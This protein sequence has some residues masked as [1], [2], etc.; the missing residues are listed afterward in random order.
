MRFISAAIFAVFLAGV[1]QA[2]SI[3]RGVAPN[4]GAPGE[5]VRVNVVVE[6]A[7]GAPA[8]GEIS[9]GSGVQ[10][11][12]I[13]KHSLEDRHERTMLFLQLE[14]SVDPSA[15]TG[16]R[17]V[18]IGDAHTN[19]TAAFYVQATPLK[20][21][22]DQQF[23]SFPIPYHLLPA[24]LDRDAAEELVTV[25][26]SP[27][28]EGNISVFDL[29]ENKSETFYATAQGHVVSARE[30]AFADRDGNGVLDLSILTWVQFDVTGGI[31]V[32]T[33]NDGN[34][35]FQM[36]SDRESRIADQ[37]IAAGDFN[38]D[39]FDDVALVGYTGEVFVLPG[40]GKPQYRFNTTPQGFRGE[41]QRMI[42]TDINHDGYDDLV[43]AIDN[44]ALH[45]KQIGISYANT[46]GGFAELR[47]YS[48]LAQE[49]A[50]WDLRVADLNGD[51]ELEFIFNSNE[52]HE[53]WVM[54]LHK[55]RLAPVFG[56]RVECTGL[57]VGDLDADGNPDV[58]CV[59][60]DI[61]QVA[62]QQR[63]EVPAAHDRAGAEV[64]VVRCHRRLERGWTR[65]S[66]GR[67]RKDLF[68]A[69]A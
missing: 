49:G 14:V 39:G 51:G 37:L 12:A 44:E 25:N 35:N 29:P 66:G 15:A 65:R 40:G 3:V 19:A 18:K 67:F 16:V 47:R 41:I 30:A 50:P 2:D 36:I 52:K 46:A 55:G 6:G 5:T 63:I 59:G 53:L 60:D 32:H 33:R 22:N 8:L 23:E 69:P 62:F 9:F 24:N 57:G 34:G 38:N 48:T 42:A 7:T 20:F 11:R 10:V 4:S 64:S 28:T 1:A 43:F 45:R 61:D 68:P 26:L 27:F 56:T 31:L 54:K 17:T 58:G 21:H 13:R